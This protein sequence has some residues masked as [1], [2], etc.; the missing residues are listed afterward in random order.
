MKATAYTF[1][2]NGKWGDITATGKP[3]QEGYVAVDRKVIPLGTDLYVECYGSWGDYGACNAQD[4]GG[5]IKGNRIDL[6]YADEDTM[7]AFGVRPVRV[8]I[9]ED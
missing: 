5:A 1:G 8:Y 9:L 2:E 3:V 4:V 6:F 7:W